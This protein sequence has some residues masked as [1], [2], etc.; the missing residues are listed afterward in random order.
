MAEE[1]RG[2]ALPRSERDLEMAQRVIA[3]RQILDRVQANDELG[4]YLTEE[5][6]DNATLLEGLALQESAQI[7][8]N[9]RQE[10]LARVDISDEA[11]EE[12]RERAVSTPFLALVDVSQRPVVVAVT[13]Q[14]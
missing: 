13:E 8:I 4:A 6:Y 9:A 1:F 10:A 12:D 3:A 5:G 2:V 14:L 11:L 7:A